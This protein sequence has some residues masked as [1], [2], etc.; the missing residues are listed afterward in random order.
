MNSPE[1]VFA[2]RSS[3]TTSPIARSASS[4]ETSPSASQRPSPR[5]C[6]V[7]RMIARFLAG[8][9][10]TSSTFGALRGIMTRLTWRWSKSKRF[11]S[12]L[13][14]PRGISP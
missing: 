14:W 8:D 1:S 7:S 11:F 6:P 2:S 9:A 3:G 5:R 13:A 12:I 10:P 4:S